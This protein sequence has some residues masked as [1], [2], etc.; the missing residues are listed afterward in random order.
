MVAVR[1]SPKR[2]SPEWKG[3]GAE[4]GRSIHP[5]IILQFVHSITLQ[6]GG[7]FILCR[8]QRRRPEIGGMKGPSPLLE[9]LLR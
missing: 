6:G 9:R 2:E 8:W 4:E 7:G 5:C 3:G 1:S